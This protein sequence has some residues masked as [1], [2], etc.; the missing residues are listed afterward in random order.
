[1]QSRLRCD[2]YDIVMQEVPGEISLAI[3]ITECPHHCVGCHSAY[4]AESYGEYVGDILPG[5]LE[6]YASLITCV[7][8][9]G[10]DQCPDD[11]MKQCEFIKENYPRLKIALYTGADN[12]DGFINCIKYLH[13]IKLGQFRPEC[14][15][16]N[17]RST[18]Q[19]MFRR[20]LSNHDDLPNWEEI[21]HLFWRKR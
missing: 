6:E 20:I 1:M 7:C 18:N 17:S 13:Y 4:L 12:T 8:F 15:G 9:M 3:N 16:L 11:L 14:G 10:G 19:I 2:G 21:T 5:A